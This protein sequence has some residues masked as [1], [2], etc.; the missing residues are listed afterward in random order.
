MKQNDTDTLL[1]LIKKGTLNAKDTF[2]TAAR[3]GD[4]ERVKFFIEKKL[5]DIN[6]V[7]D[8]SKLNALHEAVIWQRPE[9]C[10]YLLEAKANVNAKGSSGEIPLDFA[11]DKKSKN[12]TK[13]LNDNNID[14][15]K[16][17]EE[18][19]GK[20]KD[21]LLNKGLNVFAFKTTNKVDIIEW[22]SANKLN[23]NDPV[24]KE[25][26]SF[27]KEV[28]S[29]IERI[30]LKEKPEGIT[31]SEDIINLLLVEGADTNARFDSNYIPEQWGTSYWQGIDLSVML[32]G[33]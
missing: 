20:I 9:L 33:D 8:I 29:V 26:V 6:A 27:Y 3:E 16:F 19:R 18:N 5:V 17:L 30:L 24:C 32:I 22:F 14:L 2:F 7:T 4:L 1:E 11:Y 15:K 21:E 23:V 12:I 10:K 13:F 28:S 31:K 25:K